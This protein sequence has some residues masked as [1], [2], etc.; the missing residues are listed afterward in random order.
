[1]KKFL[2]TRLPFFAFVAFL[3]SMSS[4]NVLN[5]NIMLRTPKGYAFDTLEKDTTIAK[6]FHLGPN[7][8][9]EFRLLRT[10]ASV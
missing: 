1:M 8:I 9:I 7:D 3:I 5:P 2:L 4:C 10:M 6:E